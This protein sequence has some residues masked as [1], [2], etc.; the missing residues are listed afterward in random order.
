MLKLKYTEFTDKL[1]MA[2]ALSVIKPLI[3]LE[4]FIITQKVLHL[5]NALSQEGQLVSHHSLENKRGV[6]LI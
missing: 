4:F 5:E 3:C 6:R 2:C 1:A